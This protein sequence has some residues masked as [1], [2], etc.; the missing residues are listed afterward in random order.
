MKKR[1]LF[2]GYTK[3]YTFAGI[4][5]L[6][7]II[8]GILTPVILDNYNDPENWKTTLDQQVTSINSGIT[9]QI[10]T[11]EKNLLTRSQEVLANLSENDYDTFEEMI[12]GLLRTT[13][14]EYIFY[15]YE[16][17]ELL[18]WSKHGLSRFDNTL[19]NYPE[20]E[21]VFFSDNLINYFAVKSGK[22]IKG[23]KFTLYLFYPLEKD[24][25][26][27][28]KYYKPLS[29]SEELSDKFGTEFTVY[30]YP[31]AKPN[32]DGRYY[33]L[34]VINT[35]GKKIGLVEYL[36]PTRRLVLVEIN[37]LFNIIQSVLIVLILV[38][39][40]LGFSKNVWE[41]KSYLVRFIW[42]M[43]Y[44]AALRMLLFYLGIPSA[45]WENEF[46][47][48]AFFS[49]VFGY[50]IV[51]SPLELTI[52][53]AFLLVLCLAG[54]RYFTKYLS[55]SVK[56]DHIVYKKAAIALVL[57]LP[58]YML[59]LRGFGAS[60]RSVVFDSILRY[61]KD[62]A[63][64]P[65]F[66]AMLMELNILILGVSLITACVIFVSGIAV[67]FHRKSLKI[68]TFQVLVLFAIFQLLGFLYD[69]TQVDPQGTPT[70]RIFFITITFILAWFYVKQAHFTPNKFIYFLFAGSLVSAAML[71]YYNSELERESLKTTA[72]ELTRP[73]E[74]LLEFLVR[75]TLLEH[76]TPVEKNRS[77]IINYDTEAFKIWSN[78]S[79]HRESV[80]SAVIL[81]D[82]LM[83]K[84]GVFRFRLS[85]YYDNAPENPDSIKHIHVTKEDFL[86][87]GNKI[88][89][90][91]AP[92]IL[93]DGHRG[94]L[95]VSV[96]Y[97]VNTFGFNDIPGF[98]TSRK[99][100][101]NSTIDLDK[102][103]IFELHGE[104]TIKEFS[105]VKLSSAD[106]KTIAGI[107]FSEYNEAWLRTQL[108]GEDYL[109]YILKKSETTPSDVLVVGLKTKDTSW[110]LFD[111]FKIFFMHTLFILVLI[112]LYAVYRYWRVKD[113][114]ISFKTTL[115]IA[116]LV[117]S[118]IPLL[119]MAF[120]FRNL[121][122]EKN[123]EAVFYKLGKQAERI[124]QYI[125]SHI[126]ESDLPLEVIFAQ[127]TEDLGMKFTIFEGKNYYY[128][129]LAEYH[130]IGLLPKRLNPYVYRKMEREGVKELVVHESVENFGYH[131]Y[132][133]RADFGGQKYILRVSDVFNDVLLPFAGVEIDIFLF[134]TY[135]LAV[136]FI[137]VISTIIANQISSPIRKLTQATKSVASGDLSLEVDENAGGEVREL[138]AGFNLMIKKLKQNQVQL[139]ETE[140]EAAWKQMAR[141]VAHEIK[142]PLTPMKLAVQQ[143][144]AARK[145]DSPKF[146][147]IFDKVTEMV[148]NQIEILKNI[149]SEFSAFA[150]MP[151]I[152][153]EPVK[154]YE[155]LEHAA[156]LFIE[157]KVKIK[158]V[159]DDKSSVIDSDKD[160]LQRTLVNL[161]RN[162]IQA[163]ADRLSLASV[164]KEN[165]CEISV[166]DNG[167][168]IPEDIAGRIFEE[169]FTTKMS[170]MGL[171]LSMARRFI[172][173]LHGK[174]YVA[175]TSP[176]GST[177][178]IELPLNQG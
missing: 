41:S 44:F 12:R 78:S 165:I 157:E 1:N 133:Y 14:R 67:H 30:Y 49:S 174:I 13:N 173:S 23:N 61:F 158:I 37:D 32:P 10:S 3:Y 149:A 21:A 62:P 102:L 115:L 27:D 155:T 47:N 42:I 150:R 57:L 109:L 142:N 72:L 154:V 172:E 46:T 107:K 63:L 81:R 83:Q 45:F 159:I 33:N 48:S 120:Y 40:G 162:A 8:S 171:G 164:V 130:N 161:I 18:A 94:F 4:C 6:L 99:S 175:E 152:N 136:I 124:E 55:R 177:I 71:N 129:S 96:L 65:E 123:E 90:G 5:A 9:G 122:V 98:L 104:Q 131:S 73:N 92:I 77:E 74:Y 70:I 163:G 28:N 134:G 51:K 64:I 16:E 43:A 80:S 58:L 15:L 125:D 100:Y 76:T 160:Q 132:Y 138:I 135:S 145:D 140:R 117:I 89:R 87:S 167:K 143:L 38:F 11:L 126:T 19:F 79:L 60:A 137:I 144:I 26:L 169:N 106:V 170:G 84:K 141:Q 2:S 116:F 75:E 25:R 29:L 95:Q 108:N 139:A 111:F 36:K 127:A 34:P 82:S 88:I 114:T 151:R 7:V 91:L 56:S 22:V 128:S 39:L 86:Y 35:E 93:E 85:D 97:D 148:I 110:S 54:F 53:V 17:D 52:T 146:P 59:L 113:I 105:D 101:I 121:T 103:K 24:Y 20:N 31:D 147:M 176:N 68:F 119:L 153:V 166:T 69:F 156:G 50:G 118:L 168:G 112:I 178:K 66:P